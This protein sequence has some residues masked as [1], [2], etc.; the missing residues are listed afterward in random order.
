[1]E[2]LQNC[3]LRFSDKALKNSFA[4]ISSQVRQAAAYGAGVLGQCGGPAYAQ[5]CQMMFQELVK[6]ISAPGAREVE[7]V[8]PTEN[9]ISAATKILKWN[10][11][12]LN[13]NE[14]LPLW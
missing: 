11:S 5:T 12:M 13:A 1:M 7:N 10:G 3:K 14:L 2:L 9:A 4:L 6:V 8:N